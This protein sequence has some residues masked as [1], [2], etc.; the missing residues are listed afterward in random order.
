MRLATGAR[1]VPPA[2]A[3][4]ALVAHL[5]AQTVAR[6]EP[7]PDADVR[8]AASAPAAPLAP[9]VQALIARK[10]QEAVLARREGIKLLEDY[11]RTA[12]P[13]PETAEALFKLAELT[14]EDA[15]SEYLD[16]MDR[17]QAA[18]EQCR[19]E[20]A[21]CAEMPRKAPRLDL[22]KAQS[23]YAR[24]VK[25]YPQFRKLDTVLYLYA[26]SLRDQGKLDEAV[27]YF[28]RLLR[29]YPRSRFRAD[30][31]MAVGEWNFYERQSY[32]AALDAYERVAQHPRSPL[33][34]LAVFKSAWCYWKLGQTDR[35]ALRFKDVL[36]MAAQA[37]GS[38]E[39]RKRAAE[40]QD[41]AL[42][43]LVELFTE[44]DSK[45]ADDAFKF[46][47]QI[48]GK[49]YSQRVL[50]R[51]ADTVFDQARYE[52]A[53]EAYQLLLTLEPQAREAPARQ[54][55]V[56]ESY[57]AIG[58]VTRAAA[59]MRK[60]ASDYGPKSAWAKA[61]AAHPE[62]VAEAR[63]L[64]E[65]FIR[66]Q[67]KTLHAAAQKNERESKVV[68]R[69]RYAQAAE[70]YG[71]YLE[72]FPDAPDAVELRYLR[73][74]IFFFKL[75]DAR[76]AGQ[77][78]LAV[79][80]SKPVGKYH[81]DALLQAMS[82]FE[83]LRPPAPTGAAAK[84]KRAVTDDDR[85]FAEAADLYAQLL[86]NDRDIIKVIYKN[87][88][89]FY[90]YGDYD[91]A[92]KRFGL[93]LERYPDSD[94]APAAGD[95]LLECLA[96]A[97]DYA[98]IE[99]WA[100]RL[101]KTRAFAG[102]EAQARLDGLIV[103]SLLKRGDTLADKSDYAG[104]AAAYAN[105]AREYPAHAA[106]AK[107]LANAGAAYE[108]AGTPKS[109]VEAYES[110]ADKYPRASEAPEGLLT[111]A[112]IEESIGA[113]AQA[114]RLYEQLAQSYPQ[115]ERAPVALRNAGLLR[116]TLGQ[117][118][119]AAAH[120]ASY[121]QRYRGRP[122]A[123]EVELARGLLLAERSRTSKTDTKAA[124]QALGD[125]A[126]QHPND[127]RAVEA[128]VRE[129]EAYMQQN[130]DA[131]AKQAL[132]QALAAAK[133]H[134]KDPATQ[135]FAAEARTLQGDLLAREAERIKIAGRPRQLAKA[136]EEKAAKLDD[137]KKVYLD[138]LSYRVPEW[139]TAALYRIGQGYQS[140]AKAMRSAKVPR[141]LSPDEQQIYRDELEKSVVIIEDKA[142]DAFKSG[143]SKALEIGVYNQHTRL[144]RQAL[145]ELDR[146][147]YPPEA[148]ARLGAQVAERRAPLEALEEIRRE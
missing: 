1:G 116:Q 105:V 124:A 84:K 47:A 89:F 35:A 133:A 86:P 117:Y 34:G 108:K 67:A 5:G 49:A 91:E 138:V 110:L 80:K 21:R 104:A 69:E 4:I 71:F 111:A 63:A 44:D 140:F 16:R 102:R 114:A 88:Q 120:Y 62:A 77:E 112:K 53:A 129:A 10:R 57:Q 39:E 64:A 17:Y 106:A 126:R 26:F 144:L 123:T 72:Q 15:Q 3:L 98:N 82:A 141:E 52:R 66:T 41:Q 68:D 113:Y 137:A 145:A 143:Y 83:S 81:K 32:R 78:Y 46:L 19:H 75:K 85:R 54:Q 18:V 6:A 56:V 132:E 96:E 100:R 142:L 9:E 31:W 92:I 25:E 14:W 61:N 97:K 23:T 90:D 48:G 13:G 58:N 79:G 2:G 127:P 42:D 101:K 134:R 51:F 95:R 7:A 28:Q 70:A 50:V 22:N 87:G 109:A 12:E 148:E 74:D 65:P 73:A 8:V 99:T 29:E 121:E 11:L 103:Q 20:R 55:R 146:A 38:A 139:A 119:K 60:L 115:D 128:R 131:Q 30:A 59:E 147:N 107:A 125:F 76:A 93:I 122:E 45:T 136:L 24:L 94:V 36:D 33:Y 130:A 135:V 118:D 43:Y 27:V 37:K 40:L